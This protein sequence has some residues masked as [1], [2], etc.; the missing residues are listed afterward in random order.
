[1]TREGSANRALSAAIVDALPAN[2]QIRYRDL[3]A[4]PISHLLPDEL[5]GFN[6]DNERTL[7]QFMWADVVVIGAPM[8]NF[9]I[10]SNLRAWIDRIAIA[11][12]TFRYTEKGPEG[13][14][15]GKRVIIAST[16]GGVYGDAS[17]MD[18]QEAYLRQVFGFLGIEDIHVIRAEGLALS[19]ESRAQAIAAAH[20]RIVAHAATDRLKMAA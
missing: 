4:D 16:R 19:P 1:M 13:L 15:S 10:P 3:V 11:G 6:D 5:I 18:F 7:A 14:A 20:S 12:K 2:A 8:I 9:S 17:P